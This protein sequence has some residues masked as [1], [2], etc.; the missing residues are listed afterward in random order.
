MK[1][2]NITY[3]HIDNRIQYGYSFI[4]QNSDFCEGFQP[5]CR[6][7]IRIFCFL[8]VSVSYI[9]HI[10]SRSQ[11]LQWTKYLHVFVHI[12]YWNPSCFQML[13]ASQNRRDSALHNTCHR[14]YRWN[15]HI[16]YLFAT[17][18]L[19]KLY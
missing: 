17:T 10:S 8:W 14:P 3:I 1:F 4:S 15:L 6:P 13:L 7:A 16:E 12:S 9:T 19:Q 11:R 5:N 2:S 18:L